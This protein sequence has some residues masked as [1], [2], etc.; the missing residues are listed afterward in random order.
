MGADPGGSKILFDRLSI[1]R[2]RNPAV[3]NRS[4]RKNVALF[5]LLQLVKRRR[6][7]KQFVGLMLVQKEND[8]KNVA[9]LT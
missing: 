2:R 7:C 1:M 3:L 5:F 8:V 9:S 4:E 6:F